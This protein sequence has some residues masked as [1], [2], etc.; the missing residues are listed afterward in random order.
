MVL[1]FLVYLQDVSALVKECHVDAEIGLVAVPV[2]VLVAV[3]DELVQE[4]PVV[5]AGHGDF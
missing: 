1:L 2:A 5:V 3:Q 4:A